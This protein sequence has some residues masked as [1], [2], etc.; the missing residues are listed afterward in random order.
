MTRTLLKPLLHA[1]TVAMVMACSAI[2]QSRA[3]DCPRGGPITGGGDRNAEEAEEGG[4]KG[5]FTHT[6]GG[7][8]GQPS[9]V[10]PETGAPRGGGMSDGGGKGGMKDPEVRPSIT[11][12]GFPTPPSEPAPDEPVDE[13]VGGYERPVPTRPRPDELYPTHVA[14][15]PY[16]DTI[17][18]LNFGPARPGVPAPPLQTFVPPDPGNP[19]SAV[20]GWPG[21]GFFI[22]TS[23]NPGP[24]G[25]LVEDIESVRYVNGTILRYARSAQIGG[26]WTYRIVEMIDR[27]DNRTV[28]RYGSGAAGNRLVRLEHPN[29][30][31]TI[32]DY[33][34]SWI[35][36]ALWPSTGSGTRYSGLE[37]RQIA[38]ESGQEILEK[39]RCYLFKQR[40]S[41]SHGTVVGP[42]AP[43]NGDLL[44]RIYYEQGRLLDDLANPQGDRLY[45]LP[46]DLNGRDR[47]Q[48]VEYEYVDG[49]ALVAS[50]SHLVSDGI[51]STVE[52]PA[53]AVVEYEYNVWGG[54]AR[55]AKETLPLEG[56]IFDYDYT[57]DTSQT[58]AHGQNP[59]VTTR[60]NDNMGGSELFT[61]DKTGRIVSVDFTPRTGVGV[62]SRANDPDYDP[63]AGPQIEP[64]V[65]SVQYEY[66]D[67]W[68]TCN[69]RPTLTRYLPSGWQMEVDYDALTGLT[70]EVR[71]PN[72]SGFDEPAV[73]SYSWEPSAAG[74]LH[75]E[76]RLKTHTNAD[77]K[78][79]TYRYVTAPRQDPSWGNKV[80]SRTM[81]TPRIA[82][83]DAGTIVLVEDEHYN[84]ADPVLD[85][86]G[87]QDVLVGQVLEVVD[88]DGLTTR[89]DY[90]A[91]GYHER[92]VV[93]PGGGADEIETLLSF[94]R[95]GDL[96]SRTD[97]ASAAQ[98]VKTTFEYDGRGRAYRV[99]TMVDGV[100]DEQRYYYDRWG[101]TAVVL[102]SNTTSTG[103]A[104]DDFAPGAQRPD[105]ARTWL[106]DEFHY[107]GNR[108]VSRFV[109]RRALD[110]D[111]NGP[112]IDHPDARYARTDFFW[113][114]DGW[115]LQAAKPNGS[116]VDFTY[117]GYGSLFQVVENGGGA[118][119]LVAK[120]F[121][122]DR[123]EITRVVDGLGHALRYE[124]NGAGL[125]IAAIEPAT[126]ALPAGY[127]WSS[128]SNVR[129]EYD[130]DVLGR[131]TEVRAIDMSG[132]GRLYRKTIAYDEIDRPRTTELFEGTSTNPLRTQQVTWDGATMLRQFV[133]E[134]GRRISWAHDGLLR[135]SQ[136]TD[137]HADGPNKVH[138]EYERNSWFLK[139]NRRE[140]WD[141][142]ADVAGYVTRRTEFVRDNIGRVK[143]LK[144][145]PV[146]NTLDH[147][148]TYYATGAT[149]SHTDPSGKVE[150]YLVDAVGRLVER[151][152]PG[153]QPIWNGVSYLD[154]T[155]VS[156]RSEVVREDGLGHR[157]RSIFDFAG[158]LSVTMQPGASVEP[159]ASAPHQPNTVRLVYDAAS[160]LERVFSGNGV[161]V[162]HSRDANGRLLQRSRI[163]NVADL[164]VSP[165]WGR[166]DIQRDALGNPIEVR[167]YSGLGA[168]GIGDEYSRV[169]FDVDVLGR[170]HEEAFAYA[171]GVPGPVIR[172]SFAGG[173]RFRTGIE[174]QNEALGEN[175]LLQMT[176]DDIGRL[177]GVDW[178]TDESDPWTPLANY[179]FE[180]RVVTRR[181]S[182]LALA[183]GGQ[184]TFDTKF[185]FDAYGRLEAIEQ[186]FDANAGVAFVHD[187]ASNLLK[188]I[189]AKQGS[190]AAG[191]RFEYDEHHRLRKAWL[192]SDPIHMAAPSGDDP[193][194]NWVT[195]LTYGLDAGGNR[196]GVTV[197]DGPG[198]SSTT[199]THTTEIDS[200]RY[201]SIGSSMLEYDERGNTR[202][203]GRLHY[204]YD[205]LNRLSE[206]YQ[207]NGSGQ[208]LQALYLY[209]GLNRRVMRWTVGG[210]MHFYAYDGAQEV[211]EYVPGSTTD[212]KQ[213]VRGRETDELLAYR[214][215]SGGSWTNYYIAEGGAHC[216]T[217]VLD[218]SGNVVEVQEYD[219]F[220]QAT[221]FAGG[222]S[223]GTSQVDNPFAW[224]GH[225]VDP[226]TGFL[227]MRNRYYHPEWGRFVSRDPMG[228]WYDWT[229]LGNAY[230]YAGNGPLTSSDRFGLQNDNKPNG[231]EQV[232]ELRFDGTSWFRWDGSSW[233]HY[234]PSKPPGEAPSPNDTVA[235]DILDVMNGLADL[236]IPLF[237]GARD[238]AQAREEGDTWG[239]LRATLGYLWDKLSPGSKGKSDGAKG[240]GASNAA[241]PGKTGPK[242]GS[243]SGSGNGGGSKP[244]TGKS[245]GP[246]AGETGGSKA[247]A[248]ETGPKGGKKGDCPPVGP[249]VNVDPKQL[250]KKFGK[251]RKKDR[252]G[253]RTPEEYKNRIQEVRNDPNA[254]RTT[255][256]ADGDK[257][258][259]ETHFQVGDELLRLDPD[260]NFRS[261]YVIE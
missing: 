19:T 152:L 212:L 240:K 222:T 53:V 4:S 195:K 149:E 7:G 81:T 166:D 11:W 96:L 95:W 54:K 137:D 245:T 235:K 21:S 86:M 198:G 88:A 45:D 26:Q 242:G 9:T 113:S 165:M 148:F 55:V 71:E 125:V 172:S 38:R 35:G 234:D 177:A 2:A 122:N 159:T 157:T 48:V 218:E 227:Y 46:T 247:K 42:T 221:Y 73:T 168:G 23:Y 99:T 123:L 250:G 106:R 175:L 204:N 171:Y 14:T 43:F 29:G 178:R 20:I 74:N 176:S 223:H 154:W 258:P 1:A 170:K 83:G 249:P 174:L 186:S 68:C 243:G 89:H 208:Q 32:Y 77:G 72:P 135:V 182:V 231:G 131:L 188:E 213:F 47:H 37:V 205:A 138:Y 13:E 134:N 60:R 27:Y 76:Y 117:D 201:A 226:E 151:Y 199:T 75:G 202:D 133:G 193:V 253:Y 103:L 112:L 238:A 15:G 173:D 105:I 100:L 219:A 192:G 127:P 163:V 229:S 150:R 252:P 169:T 101:N 191:D 161:E 164:Q 84:F 207:D 5:P 180:G 196:S 142:G 97:H 93:N 98:P 190:G 200:N 69:G 61:M 34:P 31:D 90:G 10:T 259:G 70:T 28:F 62:G 120:Y 30:I 78:S 224:K 203:D 255:F 50:V 36:S 80:A 147:H 189:Y 197:Q 51:L 49:T 16:V 33:S 58:D 79:W 63:L 40:A 56:L 17:G 183:G 118:A 215:R 59:L 237:S 256:P 124:R 82:V 251:H 65:A 194:G 206:V 216:P 104:P 261:L 167:S 44:Y 64:S 128:V 67:G 246:A 241:E 12:A 3:P 254:T 143:Q 18:G 232:H 244:D 110:R 236:G 92:T 228:A 129:H 22:H 108:L 217:R 8:N 25:R 260:G 136:V 184:V 24:G 109:D 87:R 233:K 115:L 130:H 6:G 160:Q 153:T 141:D 145:G 116:T 187:P 220:G 156:D 146:G 181:S 209:D 210:G 85:G 111:E 91:H 230:T 121:V 41:V 107:H 144:I 114:P 39:R 57:V 102:Q 211:Q 132:G 140:A 162:A 185:D 139:V 66:G 94:D 119:N 225:R 248:S 239:E 158:R 257:F 126:T 179:G 155:G 52:S 214:V